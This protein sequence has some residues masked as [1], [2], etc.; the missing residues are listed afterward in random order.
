M[1][2]SGGCASK[3][4][5]CSESQH[6]CGCSHK[7]LPKGN[8]KTSIPEETLLAIPDSVISLFFRMENFSLI[9]WSSECTYSKA[10]DNV[11]L[12]SR[13]SE[14]WK[15][16]WL[17]I[18]NFTG[19]FYF[20]FPPSK[21]QLKCTGNNNILCANILGIF[22][23]L[24]TEVLHV[25]IQQNDILT[26][27]LLGKCNGI[28]VHRECFCSTSMLLNINEKTPDFKLLTTPIF[29]SIQMC[30]QLILTE[31]WGFSGSLSKGSRIG[32]K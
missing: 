14:T 7:S 2:Q 10:L 12:G 16:L 6:W 32:E 28:G 20:F 8:L 17:F 4:H 26:F 9:A 22:H 5:H 30:L 3:Q 15:V 19:C 29:C 31:E 25:S 24:N 21:H 18:P 13:L 27:S 1:G 23:V 11:P